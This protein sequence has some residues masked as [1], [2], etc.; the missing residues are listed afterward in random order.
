MAKTVPA[1]CPIRAAAHQRAGLRA[2]GAKGTELQDLRMLGVSCASSS[3]LSETPT[4]ASSRR[5][6]GSRRGDGRTGQ[7]AHE[8]IA[9]LKRTDRDAGRR[10]VRALSSAC[11]RLAAALAVFRHAMR[12][13]W[14]LPPGV[15][16]PCAARWRHSP[17]SARL[18][19]ELRDQLEG[20]WKRERHCLVDAQTR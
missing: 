13:G 16:A 12:C 7:Q 9:E 4:P 17:P 18:T 10:A 11:A 6:C 5:R 1:F 8:R 2:L 3:K 20:G 19:D 15:A 14:N